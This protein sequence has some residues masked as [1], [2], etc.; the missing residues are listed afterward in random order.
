MKKGIPKL[1]EELEAAH[2]AQDDVWRANIKKQ[3]LLEKAQEYEVTYESVCEL[4]TPVLRNNAA[5]LG[6]NAPRDP[7]AL[8]EDPHLYYDRGAIFYNIYVSKRD[9]PDMQGSRL[10]YRLNKQI[11]AHFNS[12]GWQLLLAYQ[13]LL[14]QL[15]IVAV[16]DLGYGYIL[17][18]GRMDDPATRQYVQNQQMRRRQPEDRNMI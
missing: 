16:R 4:L 11:K 9:N 5:E 3:L 7:V 10:K 12:Y 2:K 18:V 8:V 13:Q 17:L 1:L 14:G 15:R 6:I